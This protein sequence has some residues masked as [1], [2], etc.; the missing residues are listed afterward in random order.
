MRVLTWSLAKISP[1]KGMKSLLAAFLPSRTG[2]MLE[3]QGPLAQRHWGSLSQPG[4]PRRAPWAGWDPKMVLGLHPRSESE[5]GD[6]SRA[7]FL[8]NK[9]L[10]NFHPKALWTLRVSSP[11]SDRG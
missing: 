9:V 11:I 6:L 5:L 10:G 4:A 7:T 3:S 8:K 1:G 2:K